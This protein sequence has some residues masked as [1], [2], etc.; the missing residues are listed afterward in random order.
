[1]V[2]VMSHHAAER[3]LVRLMYDPQLAARVQ[4]DDAPLRAA[5]LGDREIGWLRAVDPRA[6]RHDPA[7]R[8][9][10]L[11]ALVEELRAS[12][13][14]ALAETRRVAFLEAF[15]SSEYFHG[16][17]QARGSLSAAYADY[18]RGAGLKTP[19]LAEVIRL[20]AELAR[21]RRE[22]EAAGG[23]DWRPPPAPA[24][25]ERVVRAPGVSCGAFAPD[26]LAA[27][28]A[29]E[30][31]LFECSLMPIV[32]LADDAP[33][34][35][36]PAPTGAPAV[37]LGLIPTQ[38]GISLVELEPPIYDTIDRA[39]EPIR[40]DAVAAQLVADEVLIPVIS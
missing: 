33:P 27:I 29:V 35:A 13:A 9:R 39:R 21:C 18:L 31:F 25:L 2:P 24:K 12:S 15:F 32:V 20:E 3:M 5:G 14:I 22:L 40:A 4:T 30:R 8:R 11:R 38:A 19:Q 7:R 16:A 26:A 34:L 1:M 23:P 6:W 10:T 37:K 28:Q 36:L 17:V